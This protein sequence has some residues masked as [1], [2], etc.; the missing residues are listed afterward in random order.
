MWSTRSQ[1]TSNFT[2]APVQATVR[3]LLCESWLPARALENLLKMVVLVR[4]DLDM[5][6]GKIPAHATDAV[7]RLYQAACGW[8][9]AG[10][11]WKGSGQRRVVLKFAARGDASTR[12]THIGKE[13]AN[14]G[15]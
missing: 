9:S 10:N 3:F 12:G 8:P 6:T 4:T 7:V 15:H 2:D 13:I 11:R 1:G 5:T 14:R